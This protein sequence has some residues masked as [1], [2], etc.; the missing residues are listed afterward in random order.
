MKRSL[1]ANLVA[2]LLGF[3]L[4][5]CGGSAPKG[6]SEQAPAADASA[7][8]ES[9]TTI[10]EEGFEDGDDQDWSDAEEAPE[11]ENSEPEAP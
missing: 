2:I 7:S 4:V 9:D 3:V 1:S 8:S 5:A 10:F 11:D 6:E